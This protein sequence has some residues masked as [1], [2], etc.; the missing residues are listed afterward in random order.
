M[1][2]HKDFYDNISDNEIRVIG[3]HLS[4]SPD[5][6]KPSEKN[7]PSG[8][9][10][11]WWWW[12]IL[13]A[14]AI[15]TVCT[16]LC[17][18][19]MG[20]DAPDEEPAADV[21]QSYETVAIDSLAMTHEDAPAYCEERNDTVNDI[22]LHIVTPLGCAP[23]LHL[24]RLPENDTTMIMAVQAADVRG[25]N[26]EIAGAY[27]YEGELKSKGKSK[28]GFCAIVGNEITLGRQA[29]TPH[30]ER[31]IEENGY[32]FRQYSLVNEGK[33]IDIKP[34]G[35]SLRRA[36]CCYEGRIVIIETAERESYHDF[37]QALADLGVE[38]ALALVGGEAQFH[39]TTADGTSHR[40][41]TDVSDRYENVNYIVW[42]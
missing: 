23:K 12:A 10:R 11:Q 2:E 26:G 29:E 27:I 41:G 4:Q 21:S 39:Y 24:G 8:K 15:A 36:L 9:Q 42:R 3:S 37:S 33:M 20:K 32:F 35:K 40:T 30:F 16:V 22:I 31:A 34:K 28:L 7:A 19:L 5:G 13:A 18:L 6:T 14:I 1:N 17:M 38:E 25:D